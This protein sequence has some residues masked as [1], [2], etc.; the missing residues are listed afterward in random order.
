VHP[1]W[2]ASVVAREP[3]V[4]DPIAIRFDR[5]GRMWV[6]EMRDYP[7]GPKAGAKPQGR[8]RILRDIDQDGVYEH[9]A[10]FAD[11][12]MFPTG[13]QPWRNGAYVTL[14]GQI[15][16]FEDVN[17]DDIA[18]DKRVCFSGFG[19]G[20]EQ[21]R[22]N[23]PRLGP[24]GLIY[25]A[26]GLMGGKIEARDSRY[27]ARDEKLDL[28]G[29]DFRF[30]PDGGSWDVVP[31]TSQYG[32]TIDDY[33]RRIGCSNRNPAFTS[34][35]DRSAL[36][37]DTTLTSRDLVY[38]VA[39]PG[40]SS[41]VNPRSNAWTTSNLHAGQF[42]A[43]CG[44]FA[45]GSFDKQS[46]RE[47]LLV[48]E[49]TA[50]LV[51]R[52]WLE[53]REGAWKATR[54]K[55]EDEF[56]ASSD[57]WLRPVDVVA[58]PHDSIYIVDMLR[59]VI[60]HPDWVPEEQKQRPDTWDGN[61][62]GRIFRLSQQNEPSVKDANVLDASI[63]AMMNDPN[64]WVRELATQS[65]YESATEQHLEA[66]RKLV[67]SD[68][69]MHFAKAR[70][71]QWL[72]ARKK[73]D[74][75]V[76]EKILK[77]DNLRL[78][79]LAISLAP[80]VEALTP[81]ADRLVAHHDLYVPVAFVE[82]LSKSD[83]ALAA[84][85]IILS[86]ARRAGDNS[87]AKLILGSVPATCLPALC[88]ASLG[89]ERVAESLVA[90]WISRWAEAAPSD[91]LRLAAKVPSESLTRKVELLAAWAVGQKRAKQDPSIENTIEKSIG[92]EG[93]R[94]LEALCLS[95]AV[96]E[97]VPIDARVDAIAFLSAAASSQDSAR[98]LLDASQPLEVR[99][100]A[101]SWLF[102]YDSQYVCDWL[103]R[104]IRSLQPALR[105]FAIDLVLTRTDTTL[106][107]LDRI[108][109]QRIAST[110]L[111]PQDTKRLTE[112]KDETVAQRSKSMFALKGD[113]QALLER[114]SATSLQ[115]PYWDQADLVA[116]K[117]RFEQSCAACHQIDGVGVNVGP[118]ISDTREKTPSSLLYSILHP[119]A[120]VDA[121]YYQYAAMTTDGQIVDGLLVDSQPRSVTIR[122]QGGQT[123]SLAR[124]QIDQ[125]QASTISLMP[126]GF[127]RV[128]SEQEM[129]NLIAYL[130]NW[131]YAKA[132]STIQAK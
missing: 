14:A 120:A 92:I 15:V 69:S 46:G 27:E 101:I 91:A 113:R 108:E 57:T 90:H 24:D 23:H 3:Q 95:C 1:E 80:D 121:A 67:S 79:G 87:Y 16:Y 61:D 49:P 29:S 58:G 119:N 112:S 81:F 56:F 131:R 50:N 55:R 130:K 28:H 104:E 122:R 52:Q 111:S 32:M 34:L 5:Q 6:V 25:V 39:A 103:E 97:S 99:L 125:L 45:E 66:I 42:S 116:G 94:S 62:R 22:A 38:D 44:V 83:K 51:Q 20:N 129:A 76:I 75:E 86:T 40:E 41:K 98:Q 70:A 123:V 7:T 54:E 88:E 110:L 12:L 17:G 10:T 8:V 65:L 18:D 31:G 105:T 30:D 68:D 71:I 72:A 21:L 33:G 4:L 93:R 60:E 78:L 64:P 43:A 96:D 63:P 109:A 132:G 26:N 115:G 48:C 47:W 84:A 85:D 37:R 35:A 53:F 73:I 117:R 13:V 2:R 89:D 102:K 106:W 100:E 19:M 114:Y 82:R 74:R 9:A 124:E 118:D 107:L 59:A 128:I 36:A 126:E 127:E 11:G 77:S